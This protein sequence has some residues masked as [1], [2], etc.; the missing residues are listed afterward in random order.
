MLQRH[1]LA[2]RLFRAGAA[3]RRN[4]RS[5]I[6]RSHVRRTISRWREPERIVVAAT[7]PRQSIALHGRG[8]A[9]ALLS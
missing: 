2:V 1:N 8:T 5:S 3:V 4:E 9:G 6:V 7:P